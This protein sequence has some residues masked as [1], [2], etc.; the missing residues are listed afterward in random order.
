[1]AI[2][3]EAMNAHNRHDLNR[4]DNS[5]TVD[6]KLVLHIEN[7]IPS[8]TIINVPPYTKQYPRSETNDAGY[9]AQSD[10]GI[11]LAYV[12]RQLAGQIVLF[13]N[14]NGYAYLDDLAV[15]RAF[16]RQGV[17]RALMQQ[18]LTWAKARHLPGIMLET[19]NI[20]VAA[21]L[22]YQRCG[23]VLG[24]FDRC[25]YQGI[26]PGTEEIALYWYLIF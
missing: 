8:F 23:F 2:S 22:F 14:W 20:N 21:C 12:D 19:Q 17:G 1:M 13:K 9:L 11:F 7:G 16:R 10:R 26:D 25:L 5:F 6:S 24:G 3:I 18:A 4:C 15:D